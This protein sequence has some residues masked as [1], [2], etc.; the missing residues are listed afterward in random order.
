MKLLYGPLLGIHDLVKGL[1]VC[2][3]D[4]GPHQEPCTSPF[5]VRTVRRTKLG[6]TVE[7]KSL[8]SPNVLARA[9][10]RIRDRVPGRMFRAVCPP[11][12]PTEDSGWRWVEA[13]VDTS[14]VGISEQKHKEQ[15]DDTNVD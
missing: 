1:V 15:S 3:A 9:S 14:D 7:F 5:V 6:T 11:G 8:L 10:Q 12:T 4:D 2:V 13:E